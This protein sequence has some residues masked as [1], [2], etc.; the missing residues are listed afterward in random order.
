MKTFAT[1]PRV[2]FLRES[3]PRGPSRVRAHAASQPIARPSITRDVSQRHHIILA[4]CKRT[5]NKSVYC[6]LLPAFRHRPPKFTERRHDGR[7]GVG[8]PARLVCVLEQT[9]AAACG[10]LCA[11]KVPLVLPRAGETTPKL[12]YSKQ[13]HGLSPGRARIGCRPLVL[14]SLLSRRSST[15]RPAARSGFMRLSDRRASIRSRDHQ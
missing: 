12:S 11:K 10:C 1:D 15:A 4:G 14:L 6:L 5:E 9:P 7:D 3:P 8:P 2:G 13:C